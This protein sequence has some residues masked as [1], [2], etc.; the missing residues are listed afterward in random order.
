MSIT[1]CLELE[2]Q[3]GAYRGP[4]KSENKEVEMVG[5][6]QKGREFTT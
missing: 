5:S 3:N 6:A 1:V 2:P 4:T